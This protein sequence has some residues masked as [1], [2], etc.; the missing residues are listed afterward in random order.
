MVRDGMFGQPRENA[1]SSRGT[2]CLCVKYAI[3][4]IFSGYALCI[5]ASIAVVEIAG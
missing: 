4:S 2:E 3:F 5:Y 1:L